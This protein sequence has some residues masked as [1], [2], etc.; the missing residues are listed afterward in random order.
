MMSHH[1]QGNLTAECMDVIHRFYRA[2]DACDYEALVA[3]MTPD[4]VWERQGKV[5]RGRAAVREALSKRSA[6]VVT[7]HL[8]QD[9]VV[10]RKDAYS[11]EASMYVAVLRHESDE[12]PALPVPTPPIRVVQL[13]RD[14]LVL[15]DEGW[16]IAHKS[17]KAIFRSGPAH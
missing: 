3:Q 8:V 15:T 7:A 13:V 11:A 9:L 14:S 10:D 1:T 16:R 4:G 12:A 5:L 2:L 17:A 6:G